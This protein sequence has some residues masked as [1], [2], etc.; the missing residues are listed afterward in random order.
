MLRLANVTLAALGSVL[1]L[2]PG[3][4]VGATVTDPTLVSGANAID[5][6]GAQ[7]IDTVATNSITEAAIEA[8]PGFQSV[9]TF[10]GFAN[11]DNTISFTDPSL[12]DIL[13]D[14]TSF[15]ST[16][17]NGIA[18]TSD[19]E[20]TSTGS[21]IRTRNGNNGSPKVWRYVID[22]G[23]LDNATFDPNANA[24]KA[25][26][27]TLSNVVGTLTSV[28]VIFYNVDEVAISTQSV[29]PSSGDL[30]LGDA[31]GIDVLFAYD[32]SLTSD[33][34]SRVLLEVSFPSGAAGAVAIGVDDVGFA[35]VPEPASL[36]LACLGGLLL[37]G[38]GRRRA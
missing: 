9:Q 29:T 11:A 24:V 6:P 17:E 33:L 16:S 2:V 13:F 10:T 31:A 28:S 37:V 23:Q 5:P 27:F 21:S 12:P 30:D 38:R 19:N 8:V 25:A 3:I 1:V 22:F 34:I 36:V 35:A 26:A 20:A 4:A 7:T 18:G 14:T 15:T 32:A